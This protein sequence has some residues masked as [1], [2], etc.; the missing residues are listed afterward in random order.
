LILAG[1]NLRDRS[2]DGKEKKKGGAGKP[3]ILLS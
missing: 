3:T 2:K 1:E